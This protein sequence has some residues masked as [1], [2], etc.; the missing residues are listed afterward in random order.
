M[1]TVQLRNSIEG[2]AHYDR[3]EVDGNTSMEAMRAL[4]RRLSNIV[5]RT[6]GNTSF[7]VGMGAVDARLSPDGSTLSVTGGSGHVVSTFAVD[8][9]QLTE[10]SNSPTALPAGSSPTG[11]VVL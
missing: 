10:L 2:R 11:L 8:G 1:A 6:M 3:R 4:K 9:G 7:R 5:Y